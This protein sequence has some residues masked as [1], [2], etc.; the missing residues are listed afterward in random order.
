MLIIIVVI[1]NIIIVKGF[2][3]TDIFF[4]LCFRVAQDLRALGENLDSLAQ[5]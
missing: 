1:I 3:M 5:M 4:M 2:Y